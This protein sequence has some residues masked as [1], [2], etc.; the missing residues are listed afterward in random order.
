MHS[1]IIF[2][3]W[4]QLGSHYFLVYLF[5]LLYIVQATMC[6]SSGELTVSMRHCYFSLWNK[7]IVLKIRRSYVAY[8]LSWFGWGARHFAT[9]LHILGIC[10]IVALWFFFFFNAGISVLGLSCYLLQAKSRTEIPA[11]KKTKT[12]RATIQHTPGMRS[13]VIKC[14]APNPNHDRQ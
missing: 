14:L 9:W 12:Q 1:C 11:C 6:P 4:S 10:C 13:H 3:K 5:Q 2:F 7:C 8:C